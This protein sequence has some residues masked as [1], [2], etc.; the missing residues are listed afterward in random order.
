MFNPSE[1]IR[2]GAAYVSLL[3]NFYF[4]GVINDEKRELLVISAYNGGLSKVFAL[5]G[6]NDLD[7][8]ETINSISYQDIYKRLTENHPS[9]E[10]RN[11]LVKVKSAKQKYS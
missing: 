2:I 5:F 9:Q 3:N 7:A 8:I 4:S 1:N 11:Y 6:K 10:T